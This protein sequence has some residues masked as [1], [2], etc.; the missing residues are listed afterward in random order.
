MGSTD[1]WPRVSPAPAPRVR[2]LT[3][4]ECDIV[5]LIADGLDDRA[6]AARLG[7][8]QQ[9]VYNCIQRIK[10]RLKVTSRSEIAQWVA[11]QRAPEDPTCSLY[12][13]ETHQAMVPTRSQT[14]TL[15]RP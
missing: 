13:L 9:Y 7:L 10:W 3:P 12:G 11:A 4:R 14:S 5:L 8:V 15:L 2:R 1:G 6:I